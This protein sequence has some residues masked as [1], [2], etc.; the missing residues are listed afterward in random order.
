MGSKSNVATPVPRVPA[1]QF[2]SAEPLNIDGATKYLVNSISLD[3]G[4]AN[5]PDLSSAAVI[6]TAASK[7]LVTPRIKTS[8]AT[9]SKCIIVIQPGGD[10]MRTPQSSDGSLPPQPHQQPPIH[11]SPLWGKPFR[12]VLYLRTFGASKEF[13]NATGCEVTLNGVL[14][15]QGWCDPWHCLWWV[16]SYLQCCW[17]STLPCTPVTCHCIEPYGT[18]ST[19]QHRTI[20]NNIDSEVPTT[21]SIW[22]MIASS[23]SLTLVRMAPRLA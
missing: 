3:S 10:N 23:H 5:N 22:A 17:S 7:H 14:I 16:H 15:H 8:A 18:S 19:P 9:S 6:D 1:W 11:S 21:A 12:N 20:Q 13:F 4:Y 2:D